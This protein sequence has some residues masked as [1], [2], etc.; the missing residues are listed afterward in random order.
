MKRDW[1]KLKKVGRPKAI[2]SP[3]RLW[4]LACDYFEDVDNNPIQ[5]E[6]LILMKLMLFLPIKFR[7]L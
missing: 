5:K 1:N 7:R 6:E 3:E 2:P 4:E